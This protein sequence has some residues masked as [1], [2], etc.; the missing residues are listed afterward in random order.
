VLKR[1]FASGISVGKMMTLM[2]WFYGCHK[3]EGLHPLE[4]GYFRHKYRRDRRPGLPIE[5]PL[6]F[7]PRR[8]WEVVR[9]H[10]GIA[11][12]VLKFARVRRRIKADPSALDYT[13]AALTPVTAD[14]QD[15]LALLV[16]K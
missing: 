10:V 6:V 1:A 8:V 12:M 15:R 13:D 16:N 2:L 11:A 7:Y 3:F 5:N 4:G 9:G 14:E